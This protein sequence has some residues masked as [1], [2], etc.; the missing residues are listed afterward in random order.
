MA[1]PTP[2]RPG[3]SKPRG[4]PIATDPD[5]IDSLRE[6]AQET[7]EQDDPEDTPGNLI[8]SGLAMAGAAAVL[9]PIGWWLIQGGRAAAADARA[10]HQ[11]RTSHDPADMLLVG[12]YALWFLAALFVLFAFISLA[13]IVLRKL[14]P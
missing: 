11:D 7:L 13:K 10:M 4:E 6:L 5:A 3:E 8:V 12:G 14:G 9:A 1:T 2:S